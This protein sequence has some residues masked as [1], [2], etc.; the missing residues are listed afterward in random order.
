M[1]RGVEDL[2]GY[3]N[4]LESKLNRT[5]LPVLM[6]KELRSLYDMRL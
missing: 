6:K 1:G 5:G 2:R 4:F 3:P